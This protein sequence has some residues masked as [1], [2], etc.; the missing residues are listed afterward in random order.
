HRFNPEGVSGVLVLAESHISI[1]T[2]PEMGYAALDVF[3]C[4]DSR[5]HAAIDVLKRGFVTQNVTVQDL[6]RGRVS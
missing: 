6:H 4:G 5:P 3:M 2:W 1:H